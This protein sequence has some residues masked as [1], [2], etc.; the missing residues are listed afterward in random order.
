M[1]K[2]Q[3]AEEEMYFKYVFLLYS[4]LLCLLSV[5]H[6]PK[7]ISHH[8]FM[9]ILSPMFFDCSSLILS[10]ITW[11]FLS[12][13]A[14]RRSNWLHWSS[15]IRR[16][17]NT[18]KR[19]LN[20]CSGRLTATR[21]KLGGWSTTT[22]RNLPKKNPVSY[23]PSQALLVI[24]PIAACTVS[25]GQSLMCGWMLWECLKAN[26]TTLKITVSMVCYD[27]SCRIFQPFPLFLVCCRQI[28]NV[29]HMGTSYCV[30]Y[31]L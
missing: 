9:L 10:V 13:G 1:G 17:L 25:P 15:T 8:I 23:N 2:K 4:Y 27:T 31:N 21:E 6:I 19:K 11:S 12:V 7:F 5:I 24:S 14:K 18:I 22:E 30:M 26:K 16:K 3:A 20:V 28:N 29:Q